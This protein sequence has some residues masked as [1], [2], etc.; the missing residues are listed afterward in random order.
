MSSN[1]AEN[2]MII[3][4]YPS[5]PYWLRPL[6]KA[7]FDIDVIPK[8]LKMGHSSLLTHRNSHHTHQSSKYL[9][10]IIAPYKD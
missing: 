4:M 2:V 7:M 5:E 9:Y 6:V 8:I 1:A 3:V 10:R